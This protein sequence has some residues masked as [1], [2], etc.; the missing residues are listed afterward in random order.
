MNTFIVNTNC[1]F[2][3]DKEDDKGCDSFTDLNSNPFLGEEKCFSPFEY[4]ECGIEIPQKDFLRE[5]NFQEEKSFDSCSFLAQE[6]FRS[7]FDPDMNGQI[8]DLNVFRTTST[9]GKSN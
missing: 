3:M 8:R 6:D 7:C 9:R 4:K 5:K 1:L 2:E